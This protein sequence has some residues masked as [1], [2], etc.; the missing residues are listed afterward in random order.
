MSKAQAGWIASANLIGY[1]LGALLLAMPGFAQRRRVWFLGG[2]VVGAVTTG[3]MAYASAMPVFLLL[4]FVGGV[5]SALVLVIGSGLVLQRLATHR[6][7]KLVAVHF[8]GVGLGIAL[9]AVGVAAL[10]DGGAG[11]Q[12]LWLAAGVAGLLPV[13]LIAWLVPPDAPHHGSAAAEPTGPLP[14]ALYRLSLCQ[15]LFGF[16]YIITA[17]FIV[18]IVRAV[19][20]AR[21]VEP[22]V[23]LVV[24][25]AAMPST[26]VWDWV[27]ARIG[28][29]RTYAV[30]CAVEAVGVAASGAWPS[31]AG[32]L[33]A[34]ALLGFTFMGI[35]ALGFGAA[36]HVAP[37]HHRRAFALV[38]ATFGIGQVL[39]PI[40][41]GW[42]F[43][44]TGS[45]AVASLLGAAGLLV[46]AVLVGKGPVQAR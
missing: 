1:C 13:P 30:A 35:T 26:A 28:V 34:A 46:A 11:W 6:W 18:A 16:G 40:A 17:T 41:G 23:W 3:A 43:D 29:F 27:S 4:R 21:G 39:G 7:G 32:A 36:R 14:R 5:A 37:G 42:L 22:F 31:A 12:G 10:R 24:G 15:A 2:L 25:L 20:S 38:T 8:A 45:F 19:P 9:S 44:R 33:V